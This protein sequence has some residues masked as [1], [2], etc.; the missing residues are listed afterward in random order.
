MKT[1]IKYSQYLTRFTQENKL[2]FKELEK[3]TYNA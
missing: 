1:S 3:S 2:P